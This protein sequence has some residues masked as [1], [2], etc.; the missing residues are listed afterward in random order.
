M[1]QNNTSKNPFKRAKAR[2]QALNAEYGK[3]AIITYLVIFG[4][5]F[6]AFAAAI[7]LGLNPTD[8]AGQTS[9]MVGAYV[10]TKAIQPFRIAATVG[11]T[12]IVARVVRRG[13]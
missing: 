11:L 13:D 12:P 8:G 4:G 9:L 10:A 5:S 3:I 6:A 1:E 7:H 2:L